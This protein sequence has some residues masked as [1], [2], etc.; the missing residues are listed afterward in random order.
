M[1]R[2]KRA[3]ANRKIYFPSRTITQQRKPWSK[4]LL[5]WNLFY[6]T[7]CKVLWP[8][9][10]A[11]LELLK[12]CASWKC[13]YC[14]SLFSAPEVGHA[15]LVWRR[16]GIRWR[17][18]VPDSIL[19]FR[20]LSRKKIY[21]NTG[22]SLKCLPSSKKALYIRARTSNLKLSDRRYRRSWTVII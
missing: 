5:A 14:A 7:R 9:V 17:R 20:F 19:D 18:Q 2:G 13:S 16:R 6:S 4:E 15:F 10:W 21:C 3:H 22:L 12:N 8:K 1:A 11:H